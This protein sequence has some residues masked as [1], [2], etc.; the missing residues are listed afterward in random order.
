MVSTTNDYNKGKK[1]HELS[2]IE[3]SKEIISVIRD[4]KK[5]VINIDDIVVGDLVILRMGM[6]IVGDGVLI[7]GNA[8]K[9]DESS[10]TGE[11]RLISKQTVVQSMI[12]R[13]RIWQLQESR[14]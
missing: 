8:V 4:G 1:F 11:T 6:E 7:E 13:E 5:S 9:V 14:K 12:E 10:M 3:K 2:S